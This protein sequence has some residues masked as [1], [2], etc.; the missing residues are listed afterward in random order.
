M[1]HTPAVVRCIAQRQ[2]NTTAVRFN[3]AF[4]LKGSGMDPC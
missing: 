1:A 4:C 3:A 2:I